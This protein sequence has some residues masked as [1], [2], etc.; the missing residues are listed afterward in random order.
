MVQ[1]S[2]TLRSREP[3]CYVTTFSFKVFIYFSRFDFMFNLADRLRTSRASKNRDCLVV[4]VG[5]LSSLIFQ[6]F[7]ELPK[8][9]FLMNV[10]MNFLTNF[11]T[12]FFDEFF[13]EYFCQIFWRIHWWIFLMNFLMNFSD[14]FF[15]RAYWQILV[16]NLSLNRD[17]TVPI[18]S[19]IRIVE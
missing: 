9:K 5:D 19:S 3:A 14:E 17:C 12:N 18:W 16:T 11:L 8:V 6:C 13:D 1:I 2:G 4:I 15:W 7:L 10:L